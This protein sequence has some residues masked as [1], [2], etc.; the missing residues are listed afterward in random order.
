MQLST[1]CVDAL[2]IIDL[3]K[4]SIGHQACKRKVRESSLHELVKVHYPTQHHLKKKGASEESVHL[5]SE[6]RLARRVECLERKVEE[7]KTL[8][9]DMKEEASCRALI[10]EAVV[11][12]SQKKDHLISEYHS[13]AKRCKRALEI[14]R[15]H[16]PHQMR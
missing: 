16:E 11:L 5:T 8:I 2:S 1:E 13:K 4:H 9:K 10:H 3:A 14:C 15:E 12:E 6:N 7:L